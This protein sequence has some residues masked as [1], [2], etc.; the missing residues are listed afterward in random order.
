MYLVNRWQV[1][2]P[3]LGMIDVV[4]ERAGYYPVPAKKPQKASCEQPVPQ[5]L[6]EQ[7]RRDEHKVDV[8]EEAVENVARPRGPQ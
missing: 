6:A 8:P 2:T 4:A 1:T 3:V 7:A 5:P